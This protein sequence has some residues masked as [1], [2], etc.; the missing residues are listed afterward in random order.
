M[1]DDV[2]LIKAVVIAHCVGRALEEYQ[3]D[4]LTFATNF[5]RQDAAILNVVRAYQAALDWGQHIVRRSKLDIPQSVRDV[6]VLL[7]QGGWIAPTFPD[8]LKNYGR[9]SQYR[10]AQLSI[11]RDSHCGRY[12]GT[13]YA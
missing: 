7:S 5:T 13:P 8:S 4:M 1:A 12:F 6:F 11:L 2:I 10:C 9:L 3:T